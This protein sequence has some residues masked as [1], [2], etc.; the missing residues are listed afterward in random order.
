[1]YAAFRSRSCAS[2]VLTTGQLTALTSLASSGKGFA[3]RV[4]VPGQ[5]I[6]DQIWLGSV[7]RGAEDSAAPELLA[8]LT[9]RE[10]Q[11]GLS[12]QG[13][14]PALSGLTLYFS[15]AEGAI[16]AAAARSLTA[17]NAYVSP[18][19]VCA[20]GWQVYTGQTGLSE[21]LLPLM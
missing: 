11:Q 3:Y 10:A 20:A 17:V 1:M 9:G 13:L 18:A 21:A 19:D 7:I 2:A 12:S 16:E 14:Y 6:T 8:F 5:V 15:G 4:M